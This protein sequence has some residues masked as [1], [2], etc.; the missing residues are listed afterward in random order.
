MPAGVAPNLRPTIEYESGVLRDRCNAQRAE[1]EHGARGYL[2][3][4]F[5]RC[6][7]LDDRRVEHKTCRVDRSGSDHN[8]KQVLFLS[9]G[10]LRIL[11]PRL[12]GIGVFVRPMK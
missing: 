3:P 4:P 9:D 12:S 5:R 8:R 10:V 11:Q 7:H 6:E 1:I 2:G